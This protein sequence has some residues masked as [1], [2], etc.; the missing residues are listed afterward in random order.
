[1]R[2]DSISKINRSLQDNRKK[3]LAT[4]KTEYHKSKVENE[5]DNHEM[6]VLDSIQQAL[7]DPHALSCGDVY[8]EVV[9]VA[10]E[11]NKKQKV[12]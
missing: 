5:L 3:N 6:D 12:G 1:M 4:V 11:E 7:A 10:Q 9:R 8:N 2:D